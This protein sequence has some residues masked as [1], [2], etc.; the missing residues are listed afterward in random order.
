MA[1]TDI[2]N[3]KVFYG[4]D[5]MRWVPL[6][7]PYARSCCGFVVAMFFEVRVKEIIGEISRLGK[8]IDDIVDLEIDPTIPDVFS[9]VV[10]INKISGNVS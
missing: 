7:A 4:E 3:A 2:F 5:K 6:V 8:V 1:P 10:F 9:E